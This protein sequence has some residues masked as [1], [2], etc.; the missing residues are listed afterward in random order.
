MYVSPLNMLILLDSILLIVV[1]ACKEFEYYQL[2]NSQNERSSIIVNINM[3]FISRCINIDSLNSYFQ[4]QKNKI[5][6]DFCLCRE[7]SNMF[8]KW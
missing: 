3:W 8:T 2:N 5:G 1:I 6:F 7:R 4:Q